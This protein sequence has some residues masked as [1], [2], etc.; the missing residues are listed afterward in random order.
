L[1]AASAH[2]FPGPRDVK[3]LYSPL[4]GVGA[5][6]VM[7][8]LAADKFENVEIYGPHAEKSGDFP[9]VPGHVSNPENT[10]VFTAMI[11][12]AK[13]AG[14]DVILASDPDCDRLGVAAP[15]TLDTAGEWATVNGNQIGALLAD[16][17]LSRCKD[18]GKLAENSFIVKTLVTTCLI[19]RI[20]AHYGVRCFG[21]LLVGFKHIA[22][23]VDREGPDGFLYGC[24]ESHG[25]VVGTYGRDKD[26]AVA[27]M[28]MSEMV[29]HL[30]HQGHSLHQHLD[31]LYRQ[32]G[33]HAEQLVN[34]FM[35]GSE[36][37]AK[38]QSLMTAFRQSPPTSLGGMPVSSVRD[39][40]NNARIPIGGG[41]SEHLEGPTGNMVIMDLEEDGNY[42]AVR[43][44]G[45]E[46][47]V[48]FY[49][50]TRLPAE[51]SQDLGAAGKRLDERVQAMAA[52]IQ[53]FADRV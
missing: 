49:M 44:S 13:V 42:V 27:S 18:E 50:F 46:P 6:A 32:H 1:A 26:G 24:E 40:Q 3:V 22:E 47:K 36:G 37:M 41:A 35:E 14:H 51:E 28:L 20:A 53:A 11:D 4:H 17:V 5:E 7:P 48:K 23:V 9:N 19:D 16:Y 10:Q 39:Y 30:R 21:D 2:A 8:L 15:L 52:D 29:A 43:P 12:Y 25:Y 34:V 31:G 38:M 33:L 45:T